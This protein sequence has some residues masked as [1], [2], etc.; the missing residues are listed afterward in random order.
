MY[1]LC[2]G[3]RSK[4]KNRR[5]LNCTFR[6]IEKNKTGKFKSF[7]KL[8]PI[9]VFTSMFLRSSGVE[10]ISLSDIILTLYLFQI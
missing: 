10:I 3:D 9:S 5:S 8:D 6:G 2:E 4:V 7:F 1:G